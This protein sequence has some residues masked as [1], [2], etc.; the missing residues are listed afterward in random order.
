MGDP[1]AAVNL[2]ELHAGARSQPGA[3][4]ASDYPRPTKFTVFQQTPGAGS[5]NRVRRIGMI[6]VLIGS[7]AFVIAIFAA[8]IWLAVTPR[9]RALERAS[10]DVIDFLV[11]VTV[12]IAVGAG[13]LYAAVWTLHWMWRHS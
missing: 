10:V 11:S 8:T 5:M 2:V 1:V 3:T 12:A 4:C 9:G 7:A 13:L 6:A